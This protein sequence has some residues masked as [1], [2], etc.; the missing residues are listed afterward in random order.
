MGKAKYEDAFGF[1]LIGIKILGL[2]ENAAWGH[3]PSR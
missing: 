1:S 3:P 2:P